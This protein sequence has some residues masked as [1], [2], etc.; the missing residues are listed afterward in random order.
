MPRPVSSRLQSVQAIFFTIFLI[1]GFV[2]IL[3]PLAGDPHFAG[4]R[5]HGYV[6]VHLRWSTLYVQSWARDWSSRGIFAALAALAV[7]LLM[8]P[9]IKFYQRRD[10]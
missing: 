6:P 2:S 4:T 9:V 3:L 10:D 1:A 7:A 5:P 8:A